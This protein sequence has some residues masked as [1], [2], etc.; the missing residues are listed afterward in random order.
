MNNQGSG[1]LIR[2][3]LPYTVNQLFENGGPVEVKAPNERDQIIY[4]YHQ[5]E[6]ALVELIAR[7]GLYL[8]LDT[9]SL[10]PNIRGIMRSTGVSGRAVLAYKVPETF[11]ERVG[12]GTGTG[13][14]PKDTMRV[15]GIDPG[16]IKQIGS[17][18]ESS[19]DM[20]TGNLLARIKK[21]MQDHRYNLG[22]LSPSLIDWPESRRA[23]AVLGFGDAEKAREEI[24][25]LGREAFEPMYSLLI[26]AEQTSR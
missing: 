1:E 26:R 11:V 2:N 14:R 20:H 19:A 10:T 15:S 8:R 13:L 23:T 4:A 24:M 5:T 18:M 25:K 12:F 16:W 7:F 17:K 22:R 21:E 3:G 9:T 6:A